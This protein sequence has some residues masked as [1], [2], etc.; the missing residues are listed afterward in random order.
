MN[1][2]PAKCARQIRD[3]LSLLAHL[4]KAAIEAPDARWW[5]WEV[6]AVVWFRL[7]VSPVSR[8]Y[9]YTR[10]RLAQGSLKPD[11]RWWC[12]QVGEPVID[13]FNRYGV[14]ARVDIWT[15]MASVRYL[16]PSRFEDIPWQS[17]LSPDLR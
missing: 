1:L 3:G 7:V 8:V 17:C 6:A 11:S 10:Y 4:R 16:Y 13:C 9:A 14:V 2:S 12:P 15:G 5:P